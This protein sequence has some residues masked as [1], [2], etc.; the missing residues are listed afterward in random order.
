MPKDTRATPPPP[1]DLG[2]TILI[3]YTPP[4]V[5]VSRRD[6]IPYICPVCFGFFLL[7][8]KEKGPHRPITMLVKLF[9]S[10]PTSFTGILYFDFIVFICSFILYT[11][12]FIFCFLCLYFLCFL[13]EGPYLLC[14]VVGTLPHIANPAASFFI[15]FYFILF[16]YVFFIFLCLAPHLEYLFFYFIII[17][18]CGALLGTLPRISICFCFIICAQCLIFPILRHAAL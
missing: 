15:L 13:F 8:W 18:F 3:F 11:F 1:P 2:N 9:Q 17:I 12:Y 6:H 7:Y 16:I 5:Y 14:P 4:F 10:H